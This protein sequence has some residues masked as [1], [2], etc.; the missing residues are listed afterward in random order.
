MTIC[1]RFRSLKYSVSLPY[2]FTEHGVAM[3]ASVLNSQAAVEMSLLIIKTF[4]KLREFF[5]THQE[6]LTKLQDL[7]RKVDRHDDEI[8]AIVE[9]IRQLMT[10]P[11]ETKKGKIGFYKE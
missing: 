3:L 9:A 7:G 2:A 5:S 11:S 4:I 6:V 1:H 8:K 10:P